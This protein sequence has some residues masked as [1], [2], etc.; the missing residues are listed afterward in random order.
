MFVCLGKFD[1]ITLNIFPLTATQL[2]MF[3]LV[4]NSAMVIIGYFKTCLFS[5][6]VRLLLIFLTAPEPFV[7]RH[8]KLGEVLGLHHQVV[9]LMTCVFPATWQS[10]TLKP[11]P[12]SRQEYA[13]SR[14]FSTS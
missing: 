5:I 2:G 14:P 12:P 7:R 8:E 9:L 6:P 11:P 10:P 13:F 3:M 1:L 4:C